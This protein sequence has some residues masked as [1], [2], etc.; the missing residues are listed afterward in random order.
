M[1]QIC[2]SFPRIGIADSEAPLTQAVAEAL[3]DALAADRAIVMV[4]GSPVIGMKAFVDDADV[5]QDAADA[6]ALGVYNAGGPGTGFHA[7]EIDSTGVITE[8]TD[9]VVI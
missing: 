6:I 1:K 5:S 8:L 3:Q 4:K 7:S 9:P 2:V